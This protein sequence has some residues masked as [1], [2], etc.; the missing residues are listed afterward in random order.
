MNKARKR[1]T[2]TALLAKALLKQEWVTAID[3]RDQ[4]G[5]T[6]GHSTVS[7]LRKRTSVTLT[8]ERTKYSP[9]PDLVIYL[10]KYQASESER[11]ILEN[12]LNKFEEG[13]KAC[14]A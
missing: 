5:D 7:D 12:Y 1:L 4:W 2:K 11:K 8:T 14:A 9:H 6:C 10:K 13:D 3:M